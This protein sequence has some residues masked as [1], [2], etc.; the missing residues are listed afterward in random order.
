MNRKINNSTCGHDARKGNK[1]VYIKC[2]NSPKNMSDTEQNNERPKDV[3][4]SHKKKENRKITW[5]CVKL[6]L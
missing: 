2:R 3:R 5:I 1:V 6:K 4:D